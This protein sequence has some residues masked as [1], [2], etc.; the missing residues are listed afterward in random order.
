MKCKIV[1]CNVRF[2]IRFATGKRADN[3][4]NEGQIILQGSEPFKNNVNEMALRFTENKTMSTEFSTLKHAVHLL[5]NSHL[6]ECL[7]WPPFR[8]CIN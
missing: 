1:L 8:Q 7:A 5:L 3:K 6:F 4:I 2:Q